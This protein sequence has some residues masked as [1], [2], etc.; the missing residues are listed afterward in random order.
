MWIALLGIA[1]RTVHLEYP[2]NA[3]AMLYSKSLPDKVN[4]LGDWLNLGRMERI[5]RQATLPRELVLHPPKSAIGR[6]AL[7]MP[8]GK[9]MAVLATM[10]GFDA[11]NAGVRAFASLVF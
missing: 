3:K 9:Q 1:E 4:S 10:L 7:G 5:S 8:D 2:G 6:V 11:K